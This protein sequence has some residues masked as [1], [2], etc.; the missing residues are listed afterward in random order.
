M[1]IRVNEHHHQCMTSLFRALC[2][3]QELYKTFEEQSHVLEGHGTRK[4]VVMK[5]LENVN[6]WKI[7]MR[8]KEKD[9]P[10]MDKVQVK[11]VQVIFENRGILCDV[12]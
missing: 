12:V 6:G 9:V 11:K 1:A 3:I 5:A 2:E 10:I 8:D 4:T 7:H